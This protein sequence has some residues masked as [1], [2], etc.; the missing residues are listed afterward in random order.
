MI[1]RTESA[2]TAH[3]QASSMIFQRTLTAGVITVLCLLGG[4]RS[5]KFSSHLLSARRINDEIRRTAVGGTIGWGYGSSAGAV[6]PRWGLGRPG[7]T[8]L[9]PCPCPCAGGP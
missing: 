4:G 1:H 2:S 5:Y 6:H 9:L 3:V 7:L 8:L